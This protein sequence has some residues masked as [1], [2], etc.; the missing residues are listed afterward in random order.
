MRLDINYEKKKK[1]TVRNRNT[2]LVGDFN[3]P[4]TPMNRSSKQKINK[5]SY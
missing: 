2:I 1:N 4:V 3:I 5:E